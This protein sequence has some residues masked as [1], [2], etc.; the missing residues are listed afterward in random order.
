MEYEP[1]MGLFK[2]PRFEQ[3]L[4]ATDDKNG[5]NTLLWIYQPGV[6]LDLKLHRCG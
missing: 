1:C 4:T 2:S 5:E 3:R 6:R